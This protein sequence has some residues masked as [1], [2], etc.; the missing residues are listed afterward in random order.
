MTVAEFFAREIALAGV[1]KD[2]HRY[3]FQ[4]S[5]NK[6]VHAQSLEQCVELAVKEMLNA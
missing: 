5:E 6:F 1:Y 2:G 4:V 3:A